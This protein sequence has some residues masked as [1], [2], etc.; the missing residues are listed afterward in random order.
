MA[1][2]LMCYIWWLCHQISKSILDTSLCAVCVGTFLHLNHHTNILNTTV[3][4]FYHD[5][6]SPNQHCNVPF[7]LYL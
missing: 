3:A 6:D 4:M 1:T 2:P 7:I 5:G